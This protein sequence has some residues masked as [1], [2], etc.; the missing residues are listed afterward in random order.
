[1]EDLALPVHPRPDEL[2]RLHLRLGILDE[3]VPARAKRR[4]APLLGVQNLRGK[5]HERLELLP[6]L[7]LGDDLELLV[8]RANR[9]A[10][11]EGPAN[12]P[13]RAPA[14]AGRRELPPGLDP[15]L[16]LQPRAIRVHH[17]HAPLLAALEVRQRQIQS[18]LPKRRAATPEVG[19]DRR[20]DPVAARVRLVANVSRRHLLEMY[21]RKFAREG[22]AALGPEALARRLRE[23]R[24]SRQ[25]RANELAAVDPPGEHLLHGPRRRPRRLLRLLRVRRLRG[26]GDG[27]E[28]FALRRQPGLALH[29]LGVSLRLLRLL[30]GF[31]RGFLGALDRGP[32]AVELAEETRLLVRPLL[33]HLL[34]VVL[35]LLLRV[36][37]LPLERSDR[38]VRALHLSQNLSLAPLDRAE[39]LAPRRRVRLRRRPLRRARD[40]I[41]RLARRRRGDPARARVR[42]AAVAEP[43]TARNRGGRQQRRRRA[44]V[45]ARRV[46]RRRAAKVVRRRSGRGGRFVRRAGAATETGAG[47]IRGFPRRRGGGIRLGGGGGRT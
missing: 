45:P 6:P 24:V 41:Q 2:R 29:L 7:K 32:D 5:L 21:A 47:V 31:P 10:R 27:G 17:A 30:R 12:A 43:G 19:P 38:A 28:F 14:D 26:R 18:L 34:A 42:A 22:Q 15:V 33:L 46:E 37:E 25:D 23:P 4:V 13:P 8:I 35:V 40:G 36:R 1:M 16:L 9:R 3:R 20:L 44:A 11:A 39:H